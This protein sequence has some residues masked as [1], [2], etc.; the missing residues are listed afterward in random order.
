MTISWS[1]ICP[2]SIRFPHCYLFSKNT[3]QFG[4]LLRPFSQEACEIGNKCIDVMEREEGFTLIGPYYV[5][6]P[7]A[8]HQKT[9]ASFRFPDKIF[10]ERLPAEQDTE[11]IDDQGKFHQND[12]VLHHPKA[13]HIRWLPDSMRT[14]ETTTMRIKCIDIIATPGREV[15]QVV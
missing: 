1:R 9:S 14:N 2:V 11:R 4:L 5:A 8:H 7:L 6:I 15:G 10:D 12:I 13:M 3:R